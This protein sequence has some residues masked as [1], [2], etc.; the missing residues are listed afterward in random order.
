MKFKLLSKRGES[1]AE[2]IVD[3]VRQIKIFTT[4]ALTENIFPL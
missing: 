4:E 2:K 1:I 3:A